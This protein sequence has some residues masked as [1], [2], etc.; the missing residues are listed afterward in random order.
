[1]QRLNSR[2]GRRESLGNSEGVLFSRMDSNRL[3]VEQSIRG[4]NLRYSTGASSRFENFVS[5]FSHASRALS[6]FAGN[7]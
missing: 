1:M 3:I 7:K 4:P 2:S 6:S 5:D